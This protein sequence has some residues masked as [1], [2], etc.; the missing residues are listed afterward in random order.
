MICL[1]VA[2]L[3]GLEFQEATV[4]SGF[5]AGYLEHLLRQDDGAST[6]PETMEYWRMDV[7]WTNIFHEK[8]SSVRE[9]GRVTYFKLDGINKID[10]KPVV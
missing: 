6:A 8:H 3:Q 10:Y 7:L 5:S 2:R 1:T 9:Y 4:L